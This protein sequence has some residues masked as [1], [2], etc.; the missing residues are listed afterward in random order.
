MTRLTSFRRALPLAVVFGVAVAAACGD[1]VG[2]LRNAPGYYRLIAINGQP[3]PYISPPSTG[4]PL[5]ISRGDLVL[6]SNGSFANGLGANLGLG[7]V[8]EGTYQLS[9]REISLRASGVPAG[10]EVHG[11]MSGD[12][13]FF[14]WPDLYGQTATFTYR[15]ASL[16]ANPVSSPHYRLRSIDGRTAEPLIAYDTTIAGTHYVGNVLFDSLAFSDGVFFRQHRSQSAVTYPPNGLPLAGGEEWITWGAYEPRPG[17]VVLVHYS[18]PMISSPARDS[19][20]IAGD[21]LIRR[22][23]L[24]TGVREER[25]VAVP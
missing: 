8:A 22:T 7:S 2:P 17:G 3:L 14:L 11:L 12:S 13:I 25:Y 19:L 10:S 18:P 5:A 24:V 9:D 15:R 6:R 23:T 4:T 20:A 1:G 16:P 21:T